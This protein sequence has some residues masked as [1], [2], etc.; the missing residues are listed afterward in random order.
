MASQ[1]FEGPIAPWWRFGIMWLVIGGPAAVVLASFATLFIILQHPD[2]VVQAYEAI[3]QAPATP[4]RN[5]VAS[6]R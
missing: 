4:A 5:P 6:P 1:R 2:P 3:E